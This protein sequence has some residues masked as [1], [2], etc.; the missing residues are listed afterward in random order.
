M[1]TVRSLLITSTI[2]TASVLTLAGC[3]D[4]GA[5]LS[6]Y[7]DEREPDRAPLID[8]AH[9]GTDA[10]PQAGTS[11]GGAAG[12]DHAADD[13]FVGAVDLALESVPGSTV[14]EIE[15][16]EHVGGWKVTVATADGTAHRLVA[17]NDGAGVRRG[18]DRVAES[19]G[20]R[21]ER[22]AMLRSAAVDWER[23]L[24][25]VRTAAPGTFESIELDDTDSGVSWEIDFR[26]DA[27]TMSFEVDAES[28]ALLGLD[29]D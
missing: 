18:P 23:A 21:V 27:R 24:D 26:A 29:R 9:D 28:G 7:T 12:S 25:T 16:L 3:F 8:E 2:A 6:A 20:D 15:Q 11:H 14:V 22:A 17:T 4:A 13:G 19:A 1:P 5:R 10:E